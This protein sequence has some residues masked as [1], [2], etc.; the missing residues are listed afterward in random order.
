[1]ERKEENLWEETKK[2]LRK[3]LKLLSEQSQNCKDNQSELATLSLAMAEI[4]K[5]IMYPICCE[6]VS[7]ASHRC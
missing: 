2:T 7:Q 1:M 4:A 3:Q 5:T 6:E